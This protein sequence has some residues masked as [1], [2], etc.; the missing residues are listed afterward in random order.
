MFA[1]SLTLDR[2]EPIPPTTI[3]VDTSEAPVEPPLQA[4]IARHLARARELFKIYDFE[5]DESEWKVDQ[6]RTDKATERVQ[7]TIR[8]RVRYTCHTCNTT[9]GHDKVCISCQHPR[10]TKCIRYPPRKS[11]DTR[12]QAASKAPTGPQMPDNKCA[13][14]ECQTGFGI[15][16]EECPNCHHKICKRCLKEALVAVSP[17]AATNEPEKKPAPSEQPATDSAPIVAS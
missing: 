3:A 16:A 17:P 11:K 2:S 13:C 10:C 14:H 15:A 8:M 12:K 5:I 4:N 7:K 9:F 6:G 1:V